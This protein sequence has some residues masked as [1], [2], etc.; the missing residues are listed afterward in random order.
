MGTLDTTTTAATQ[1]VKHYAR[2]LQ[3]RVHAGEPDAVQSVRRL[4]EY[5]SAE[6]RAIARDIRRTQCLA[7]AALQLGFRSW[8]HAVEVFEG[9]PDDY[10]TLL[11]PSSCSGHSNIW[12]AHYAEAHEIRAA[13]GG[14]LLAYR[15]Q[16]LIVDRYYIDSLGLDPDHGAW[17][18]MQ[19]DWVQPSDRGA[20]DELYALLVQNALVLA[21]H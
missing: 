20:R 15:K 9:N 2:I 11:Y 13:H 1:H 17:S 19:R 3:R 7:V 14:Y 4:R 21:E 16:F 10:G 12:S 6:P 8:L 18:R 5:A